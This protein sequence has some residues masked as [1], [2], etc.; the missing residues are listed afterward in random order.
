MTDAEKLRLL[1]DWFDMKY[2]HDTN[3]EVQQDLRRIANKLEC[4]P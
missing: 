3:P 1:A 2:P 4:Q